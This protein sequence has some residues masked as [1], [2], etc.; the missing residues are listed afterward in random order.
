MV[1][2]LRILFIVSVAILTLSLLLQ[3]STQHDVREYYCTERGYGEG[4]Y[5]VS[6][7]AL[8]QLCR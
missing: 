4:T 8:Q 7:Q 3:P 1:T 2:F 6:N 5:G